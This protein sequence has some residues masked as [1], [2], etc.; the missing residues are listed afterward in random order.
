LDW[1]ILI[2][3][4]DSQHYNTLKGRNEML[5]ISANMNTRRKI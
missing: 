1:K 2:H 4:A 5:K 3:L